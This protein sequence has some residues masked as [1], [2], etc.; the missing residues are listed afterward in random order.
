MCLI[1]SPPLSQPSPM[2]LQDAGDSEIKRAYKKAALRCHPDRVPP[3]EKDEAEKLFKD[4]GEAYSVL[5]DPQKKMR[6]DNGEVHAV[7]RER[8]GGRERSRERER[9]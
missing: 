8:E 2:G 5:S 4:V 6:Y 9:S 1:T 3:E 7:A